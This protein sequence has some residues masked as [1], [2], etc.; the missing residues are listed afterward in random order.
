[1]ETLRFA[2]KFI[3]AGLLGCR[4]GD[5][6]EQNNNNKSDNDGTMVEELND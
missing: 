2:Y 3:S 5:C 4:L 6:S 1:M